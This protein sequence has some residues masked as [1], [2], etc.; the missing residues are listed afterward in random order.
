MM[1]YKAA[2]ICICVG[3]LALSGCKQESPPPDEPQAPSSAPE[4][5][6]FSDKLDHAADEAKESAKKAGEKIDGA[7]ENISRDLEGMGQKVGEAF[8]KMKEDVT[9]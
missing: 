1:N 4:E 3:V 7:M 2:I 5:D 8:N 6:K 9:E